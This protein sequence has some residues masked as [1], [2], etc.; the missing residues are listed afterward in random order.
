M[1]ADLDRLTPD[2]LTGALRRDGCLDRGHVVDVC[3]LSQEKTWAATIA[4]LQ[5]SY[6]RDASLAA[7][8]R[9]FFKYTP[10]NLERDLRIFGS[11]EATFYSTIA[12]DMVAP[13]LAHC[14]DAD[15]S[16]ETGLAHILLQ[17][18]SDTH[19]QSPWPLPPT[20][21]H[22]EAIV[23]ALAQVH[24]HWW[25]RPPQGEP[26]SS[27]RLQYLRQAIKA[28]PRFVHHLKDRLA[29][30]RREMYE[31]VLASSFSDRL[32]ESS[33]QPPGVTLIH[34]DAHA[35]NFFLPRRLQDQT[36]IVD[37]HEWS[38]GKGTDDLVETIALA[39][40]PARRARLERPLLRHYYERLLAYGVRDHTWSQCWDDYRASVIVGLFIPISQWVNGI[41][42]EVW[43][44]NLERIAVA[45]QTLECIELL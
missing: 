7:P 20:V 19:V 38:V 31:R 9:L 27:I 12:A 14:Y 11:R 33:H 18:L 43:W 8:R 39:W 15:C 3:V 16:L 35:W 42:P 28:Y 6:S 5:V 30:D 34:G 2:R 40:F 37:W 44:G 17:D 23:D 4:R 32:A 29:P 22:C 1:I 21:A 41:S 10:P 45:Y 25:D 24:A 26:D 36:C 13:P